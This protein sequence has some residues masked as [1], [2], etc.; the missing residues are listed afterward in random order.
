MTGVQFIDV[1]DSEAIF[2]DNQWDAV[3]LVT[4]GLDAIAQEELAMLASHGAQVD[5]R[6]GRSTTLLF[7]PGLA[8]GRLIVAPVADGDSDIQDVR[9]YSDAARQ[10]IK[11]AFDAGA[12]RPLLIVTP[13]T[14][15]R[16][17]VV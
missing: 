16:K 14:Q 10:G 15:D 5:A 1:T 2:D 4:H 17:S 7:A 13:S 8:G 11:V 6:V 9:G 3:V 12:R